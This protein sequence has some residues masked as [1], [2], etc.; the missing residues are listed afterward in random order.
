MSLTVSQIQELATARHIA[1]TLDV[2]LTQ[3]ASMKHEAN[4]AGNKAT[5]RALGIA[6]D[7]ALLKWSN[8]ID[9]IQL[10]TGQT[11]KEAVASTMAPLPF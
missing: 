11:S 9:T 5:A 7:T 1:S 4:E 6:Y 2:T 3:I 10:L 8:A